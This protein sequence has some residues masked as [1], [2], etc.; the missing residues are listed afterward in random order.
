MARRI[1]RHTG[2]SATE[3]QRLY[4]I[5]DIHGRLDL[6]TAVLARVERDL[7]ARPHPRPRFIL[8]GDYVDRGPDSRGVIDALIAL[9]AGPVPADFLLGNHDAYVLAYLRDPDWFDLANHWLHASL[10]GAA[11]LASYGVDGADPTR[12]AATHAAFAAAFPRT[13][14]SFLDRCRLLLRIGAY[15]FVH[16]GIRPGVPLEAQDRQDLIWIR[17]PFLTSTADFG[18]KVVHGHTIV[19]A[20]EHHKNR[21][22]IDT[23]AI[24]SGN[25]SCLVL[26]DADASLLEADGL[27][28]LPEGAGL[29]RWRSLWLRR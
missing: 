8:L 14:L 5:G 16:A 27:R 4:V 21:I 6:L 12:P 1:G 29:P 17:D 13:H 20:V 24:R 11:T 7:S 10:G 25:L 18:F 15:V 9:A 23:G 2:K 19:P 26:E 28:P 3:G 22:A